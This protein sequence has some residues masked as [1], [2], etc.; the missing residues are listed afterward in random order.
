M[1]NPVPPKP[2]RFTCK[3]CEE[4]KVEV[5]WPWRHQEAGKT[6]VFQALCAACMK[7]KLASLT[8]NCPTEEASKAF[9]KA[10]LIKTREEFFK[11]EDQRLETHDGFIELKSPK[12]IYQ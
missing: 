12:S 5:P 10:F 2:V 1:S 9:I 3:L 6:T 11:S 4:A 8:A 7:S